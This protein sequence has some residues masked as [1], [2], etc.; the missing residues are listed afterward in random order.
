M[1]SYGKCIKYSL[2]IINTAICVSGLVMLIAG[3][4]TQSK[5]DD[6]KMARSIG[7]YSLQAG[8]ELY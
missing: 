8:N 7:G 5:I 6:Q 3:A 2:I 4:V 1:S